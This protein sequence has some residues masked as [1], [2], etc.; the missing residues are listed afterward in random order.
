MAKT[1]D[2]EVVAAIE[3]AITTAQ[4]AGRKPDLR[5]IAAIFN[6][7]YKSVCS[8]R[9]RIEKHQRTGIDDRKRPGRKALADWD[10]VIESI[11]G[12]LA[13]RPGVHQSAICDYVFD[14]FGVRPS[15]ATVSRLLRENGIPHKLS[16]RLRPNSNPLVTNEEGVILGATPREAAA[17]AL[18]SLPAASYEAYNSPYSSAATAPEGIPFQSHSATPSTDVT[19]N[20]PRRHEWHDL[21]RPSHGY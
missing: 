10:G 5:G 13:R 12:F 14:E 1:L 8:I 19:L 6:C 11:R 21:H 2:K 16:H 20:D 18:L 9:R 3:L 7:T 15:Q 4:K 17:R